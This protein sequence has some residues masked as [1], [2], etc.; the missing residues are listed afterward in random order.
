MQ[1]LNKKEGIPV[2]QRVIEFIRPDHEGFNMNPV[3][4]GHFQRI[5][6]AFFRTGYGWIAAPGENADS[7]AQAWMGSLVTFCLKNVSILPYQQILFHLPVDFPVCLTVLYGTGD[8][9]RAAVE[10]HIIATLTEAARQTLFIHDITRPLSSAAHREQKLERTVAFPRASSRPSPRATWD[11]Q[12]AINHRGNPIPRPPPVDQGRR[13]PLYRPCKDYTEWMTERKRR[14]GIGCGALDVPRDAAERDSQLR[15]AQLHSY[16]LLNAIRTMISENPELIGVLQTMR[17]MSQAKPSILEYLLFIGIFSDE[18]SMVSN[19]AFKLARFVAYGIKPDHETELDHDN[20]W[21]SGAQGESGDTPSDTAEHSERQ[22]AHPLYEEIVREYAPNFAFS[23]PPTAQMVAAFPIFWNVRYREETPRFKCPLIEIPLT[24]LFG[25]PPDPTAKWRYPRP[26]G[27][28]PL[29]LFGHL[30]IFDPAAKE[31]LNREILSVLKWYC[32]ACRKLRGEEAGGSTEEFYEYQKKVYEKDVVFLDFLRTHF[33]YDDA[34]PNADMRIVTESFPMNPKSRFFETA[35]KKF[36][37]P[38]NGA[39]AAF[40]SFWVNS[41]FFCFSTGLSPM[42]DID[43]AHLPGDLPELT[44]DYIDLIK[45]FAVGQPPARKPQVTGAS[46]PPPTTGKPQV[47]G[48]SPPPPA[49]PDFLDDRRY[50]NTTDSKWASL[51]K[52]PRAS[53]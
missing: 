35:K 18:S 43:V 50:G 49:L 48:A 1:L 15:L 4:E 37:V 11:E 34:H 36:R 12:H 40:A 42:A 46:P 3:T 52:Q 41:D 16:L 24:P 53:K 23:Y 30:L 28:T 7:A 44:E 26:P 45:S 51:P 22:Y 32:E 33:P 27:L 17:P 6:E 13:E 25:K 5:I 20:L 29:E 38:L 19:A 10:D 2:R 39:I 8:D 21:D 14:L 47:T 9:D 31:S